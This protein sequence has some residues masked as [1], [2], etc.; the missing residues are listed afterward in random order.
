MGFILVLSLTISIEPG[1]VAID[2]QMR[3]IKVYRQNS[4]IKYDFL[5]DGCLLIHHVTLIIHE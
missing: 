3:S 4:S 1:R 2:F 5:M